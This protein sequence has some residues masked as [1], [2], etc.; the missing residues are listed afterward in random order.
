LRPGSLV[1]DVGCGPALPYSRPPGVYIVGV[2]PSFES[3]R[4]N[5]D[6]DLRIYGTAGKLPFND[7]SVDAVVCLYSV[8][9]MVGH[10]R[11]R[12]V[13]IVREALREFGRVVKP[14]GD[15]LIFEIDPWWPFWVAQQALWDPA[16]RLL[17]RSLD[18]HFWS[19]S[20][21]A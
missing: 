19:S 4:A 18:M 11:S 9:H 17:G 5:K 10:A 12:N 21:L 13:P 7:G 8:H 15:V 16:R 14:G 20:S 3:V 2:D 1:V 6:V